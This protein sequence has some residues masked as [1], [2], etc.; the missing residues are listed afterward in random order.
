MKEKKSSQR[1]AKLI[2]HSGLCSR[3]DAERWI[4]QGRVAVDG[5]I[6]Y[7][8]ALNINDSQS[9]TVDGKRLPEAEPSRLWSYYKPKGLIITHHDP[10]GRPTVFEV[11]PFEGQHIIS[12]G[13][14][15]LFSEGLL[16]LTNN[17]DL[18]R[19]LEHPTMEWKRFY[20][21]LIEGRV[22][23]D[24]LDILKTGITIEGIHYR[25]IDAKLEKRQGFSY[26]VTFILI[27]GKNREIRKIID[28]LGWKIKRLIR[29]AYGPFH[30][31]TLQPGEVK[32]IP[33]KVVRK[34][35]PEF[36]LSF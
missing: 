26:W 29:Q 24:K 5:A 28:F 12:I 34:I 4:E 30:L 9:I 18:A 22:T 6:I 17:G 36:I 16:L 33:Q 23:Q 10:E 31:G 20:H 15:D 1:I 35:L 3:R 27:E 11:L 8:P 7:S 2:A 13:R 19:Y 25:E 14:L 21:V 32:E